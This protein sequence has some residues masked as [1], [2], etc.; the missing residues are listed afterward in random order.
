[1]GDTD[2]KKT[3]IAKVRGEKAEQVIESC[4]GVDAVNISIFFRSGSLCSAT[5]IHA[6]KIGMHIPLHFQMT[7]FI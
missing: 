3:K 1:M 2:Y 6:N 4:L 7:F 5:H